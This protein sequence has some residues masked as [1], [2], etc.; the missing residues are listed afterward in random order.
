M[1]KIKKLAIWTFCMT[2]ILSWNV[3][4]TLSTK[5]KGMYCYVN[6]E[7]I[8][9]YEFFNNNSYAF[10]TEGHF[11]N[12]KTIGVFTISHDTAILIPNS[13][14]YQPDSTNY[15]E[16]NDTLLILSDSVLL[17]IDDKFENNRFSLCTR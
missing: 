2:I 13:K 11:G 7:T 15:F 10:K 5:L 6:Y 12:S 3:K 1:S 16:N 14:R 8:Y 9:S 17:S 4:K